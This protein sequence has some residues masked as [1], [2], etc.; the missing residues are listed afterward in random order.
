MKER[1]W[2]DQRDELAL[3]L[4]LTQAKGI[5]SIR[6]KSLIAK[7]TTPSE[8]LDASINALIK[9]ESIERALAK[10][11]HKSADSDFGAEQIKKAESVGAKVL[12]YWSKDYPELLKRIA[13]PPVVL[14][15]QGSLHLQNHVA[16]AIVGTRSP[17]SYGKQT[18]E[19]IVARLVEE[20]VVVVSGFARG[21]DTTAHAETVKRGGQ[22]IAVLGCGLDI[23]Y[24]FENKLLAEKIVKN[25]ALISE[26]PFGTKPDAV[27]FPR[28]NRI[29]SGLALGTIIVEAREKSGALIT[30]NLALEQNREVFAIPGSIFSPLSLG[31]HRLIQEGAKLVTSLEDIFDEIPVQTE[32]FKKEEYKPID[33]EKISA[34][35][36]RILQQLSRDPIHIDQLATE[37]GMPSGPLLSI[38]LH[39]EFAGFVKQLPGKMFVRI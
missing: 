32:L 20:G 33:E 5:G 1:N 38:L 24:P 8:V 22:T 19:K 2:I 4:N 13:D 26:F 7:F 10:E 6:L 14:F 37:A 39:L 31:P 15:V 27:N 34:E 25:G 28:R 11:I 29:I 3:L 30:A 18:T 16:L 9:I 12:V 23:L 21:I 35:E 36:K 17:S